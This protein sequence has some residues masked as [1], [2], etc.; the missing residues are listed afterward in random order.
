MQS[1]GNK[2]SD[3]KCRKN[4]IDVEREKNVNRCH[5]RE[6]ATIAKC[7]KHCNRLQ[8][9]ETCNRRQARQHETIGVRAG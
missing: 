8:A 2:E 7:G 4:A 5:G 1:A 3:A 9:R 6:N